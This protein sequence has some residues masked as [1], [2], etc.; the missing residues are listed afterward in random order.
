MNTLLEKIPAPYESLPNI[1]LYMDQLLSIVGAEELTKAMVNN[2][3]KAGLLPR[4][5]GKR[6]QKEH[7]V[8]L[9]LIAQLKEVYSV[10][11]L[12]ELMEYVREKDHE[13]VYESYR[14]YL[15]EAIKAVEKLS[16]DPLLFAA[17]SFIFKN[18]SKKLLEE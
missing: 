9:S 1:D 17:F 15:E 2:Y 7:V 18:Q 5:V 10:N 12:S 13:E 6:Y 16:E 4:A 3:A 11:E 8:A 14:S